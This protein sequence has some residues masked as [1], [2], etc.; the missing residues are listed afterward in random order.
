MSRF[1]GSSSSA[2]DFFTGVLRAA[3]MRD[4][5]VELGESINESIRDMQ[6][7][8]ETEQVNDALGVINRNHPGGVFHDIGVSGSIN[9]MAR[10]SPPADW[11]ELISNT[12]IVNHNNRNHVRWTDEPEEDTRHLDYTININ[13]SNISDRYRGVRVDLDVANRLEQELGWEYDMAIGLNPSEERRASMIGRL[14]EF[15]DEMLRSSDFTVNCHQFGID[16]KREEVLVDSD[17]SELQIENRLL[18]EENVQ[19]RKRIKELECRY[20][21]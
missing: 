6:S 18:E 21:E 7:Q 1:N 19:L 15:A 14:Q 8:L 4:D 3:T 9:N 2:R 20:M 12:T 17:S 16:K 5:S 10:P 11:N 13:L